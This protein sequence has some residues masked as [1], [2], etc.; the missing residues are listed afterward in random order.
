M[1]T[2]CYCYCYW[3]KN[4]WKQH[5]LRLLNKDRVLGSISVTKEKKGG[6]SKVPVEAQRER[7]LSVQSARPAPSPHSCLSSDCA[8][9]C[10]EL[11]ENLSEHVEFSC[12]E[13]AY[14]SSWGKKE[15]TKY[16]TKQASPTVAISETWNSSL[17]MHFNNSQCREN[18]VYFDLHINQQ[19]SA[20][21][22]LCTRELHCNHIHA[23]H[24]G[25][26]P[27]ALSRCETGKNYQPSIGDLTKKK[28]YSQSFSFRTVG[29]ITYSSSNKWQFFNLCWNHYIKKNVS[30]QIMLK[31]IFHISVGPQLFYLFLLGLNYFSASENW[32]NVGTR[33]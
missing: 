13:R 16:K 21:I 23:R 27:W 30:G 15:N 11:N 19:W 1:N 2:L 32:W 14:L 5:L 3:K 18:D 17:L 25:Q 33:F 10:V 20:V 26:V 7:E 24:Q 4:M 22:G 12:S 9:P 29:L 31:T 8:W 28:K 6:F